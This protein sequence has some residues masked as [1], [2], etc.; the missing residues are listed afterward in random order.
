MTPVLNWPACSFPN[1]KR[2][3]FPALE[4]PGPSLPR[5]ELFWRLPTTGSESLDA[6]RDGNPE[7]QARRRLDPPDGEAPQGL[8]YRFLEAGPRRGPGRGPDRGP[9]T[10]LA[11]GGPAGQ[12]DL[13]G[14][15]PVHAGA[16]WLAGPPVH[17]P[18]DP[19]D[20]PRL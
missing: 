19:D 17:H 12:V 9:V 11:P 15:G 18:Q 2:L 1:W 8:A 6:R 5:G 4:R 16:A 20:V 10:G 7:R 3:S 13:E 14:P